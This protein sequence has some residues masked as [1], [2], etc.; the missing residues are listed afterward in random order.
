M[1]TNIPEPLI[2]TRIRC[3]AAD[4]SLMVSLAVYLIAVMAMWWLIHDRTGEI[5]YTVDDAYI[6]GTL[7]R[8][9]A[10]HGSFGIVP[11]EF[12]AASSS[13]LWTVLMAVIFFVTGAQSWVPAALATLFGALAVERCNVLLKRMGSG[14]VTRTTV[15][16]MAIAFAPLLPIISTG[17][18][19]T[20][21]AWAL[22]GLFGSLL[23]ASGDEGQRP[24]VIFLW[25]A[26]AAGSRYESLFA[27][28]PLLIWLALRRKWLTATGLA[29]G[30]ALPVLAFAAYSLAHGGYALP[31]SLMLKGNFTGAFDLRILNLLLR[32]QHLMMVA[33][34]LVIAALVH[35]SYGR[36]SGSKLAWL[37]VTV[38]VMLL[39]HVQLAQLG[40]F[41]RY[42]GY[43]MI[44]G[45]LAATSVFIPLQDW[46][47]RAPRIIPGVMI[48][49]LICYTYPMYRRSLRAH[50]DIVHAVGNVHDQQRQM[51]RVVSLLGKDAR[52]AANDLGAVSFFSDARVLDLWGLG[53]NRI[54]RAKRNRIKV[55]DYLPARIEEEKI[56]FAVCYPSWFRPP[57]A[58]PSTFIAVEAW[59][60]GD[61]LICGSDTVVF[62]A[63]SR[64]AADRLAAALQLYRAGLKPDPRSTN[65]MHPLVYR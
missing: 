56:E 57:T 23:A 18:E 9:I 17:M 54:A 40:W 42:E 41:W 60:L 61:N 13:P 34:Y 5:S 45:L 8:N 49:L 12:A 21:H 26:L 7:A 52:V 58:L 33:V 27:L 29:A 65:R 14:P 1:R 46:L 62:Y 55:A 19:H 3:H 59:K 4:W 53:D 24:G 28:P 44:L 48:A 16:L 37:P 2:P 11:G 63:A 31:N 30:M 6:H 50:S 35:F 10:E 25:A 47:A 36:K 39:T 22:V 20:L 51:A 43:L 32:N 15:I 64:E 38:L